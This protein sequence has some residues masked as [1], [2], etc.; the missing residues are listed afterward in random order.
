M[1]Q[2]AGRNSE[3]QQS[4]RFTFIAMKNFDARNEAVATVLCAVCEQPITGGRWFARISSG[5]LL[6]ALCCPLCEATFAGNPAPYVRRI[7][8]YQLMAEPRPGN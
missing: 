6:A 7:E 3:L 4:G 5:D 2:A 1:R 8:T